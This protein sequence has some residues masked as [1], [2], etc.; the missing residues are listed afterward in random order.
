MIIAE[1][2]N[3]IRSSQD[4]TTS[5]D[6]LTSLTFGR[7]RYLLPNQLLIPF[8][9]KAKSPFTKGNLSS[10]IF[11]SY[12]RAEYFFWPRFKS[13]KEPDLVVVLSNS[14]NK[15]EESIL[16]LFEIKYL[17]VK[18]SIESCISQLT[19][20]EKNDQLSEYFIHF[21]LNNFKSNFADKFQHIPKERRYM[22]YLTRHRYLPKDEF[23]SSQNSKLFILEKFTHIKDYLEKHM[24]WLSWK[25]LQCSIDE[26]LDNSLQQSFD[27]HINSIM[28]LNDLKEFMFK[29]NL[30][31]APP[32]NGVG[33]GN[34]Q[35]YLSFEGRDSIFYNGIIRFDWPNSEL[36]NKNEFIFYKQGEQDGQ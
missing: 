27:S 16:I 31:Y 11:N 3:K 12:G 8:I 9:G 1:I 13:N 17:N 25:D 28:I 30:I 22:I 14:T 2:N 15:K 5:E 18:S 23:T 32:F 26:T 4:V 7:I 36:K 19:I 10:V 21:M 34:E 29:R 33:D 20:Q 6:V 35:V 24:F